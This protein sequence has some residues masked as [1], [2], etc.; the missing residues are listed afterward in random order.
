[1]DQLITRTLERFGVKICLI[2]TE[3]TV[4]I[5]KRKYWEELAEKNY[6]EN[7]AE[8]KRQKEIIRQLRAFG[9]EKQVKRARSREKLLDKIQKV[10]KPQAME[11]QAQ[12]HF[13]SGCPKWI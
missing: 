7:Q 9:R 10:E 2:T 11:R 3:T 1:M 4:T 5:W 13:F 12:I 8:I 6:K